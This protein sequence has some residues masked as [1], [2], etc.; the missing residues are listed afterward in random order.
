[1]DW[2]KNIF[3][4]ENRDA[5]TRF[6]RRLWRA[7]SSTMS[8]MISVAN[9]CWGLVF[10]LK[11]SGAKSV[12]LHGPETAATT[13]PIPQN[14]EYFGIEFDLGAF[15]PSLQM[16]KLTDS[17]VPLRVQADEAFVLFG[18]T[19]EIPT[20]NNADV[21][22]DRLVRAGLL[23]GDVT[24]EQALLRQPVAL[25]DRSIQRRF[26][27]STG[28][29]YGTIRQLDRAQRAADLL[30]QGTPIL[31]VVDIEGFSDQAHLTRSVKKFLGKTP[32]EILPMVR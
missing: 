17:S 27:A 26:M 7:P 6:V 14:A 16:A 11:S 30:V 3:P 31:D 25:T 22:V 23:V 13:V 12:F 18:E 19:V 28:M 32:G 21:F 4:F 24:V 5:P 9:P 10:E 20:F 15:M 8:N 29:T 1:M 2:A